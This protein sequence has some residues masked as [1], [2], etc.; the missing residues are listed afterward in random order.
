MMGGVLLYILMLYPRPAAPIVLHSYDPEQVI[1]Q[2][3]VALVYRGNHLEASVDWDYLRKHPE[4]WPSWMM[5]RPTA[6]PLPDTEEPT[7]TKGIY[8]SGCIEC[9]HACSIS[10]ADYGTTLL[11]YPPINQVTQNCEHGHVWVRWEQDGKV[12]Y[13]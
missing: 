3:D 4:R 11:C 9:G 6:K 7:P 10:T 13:R 5:E 8:P 2:R 12:G 1:A